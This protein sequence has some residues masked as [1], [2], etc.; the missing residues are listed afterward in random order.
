MKKASKQDTLTRVLLTLVTLTPPMLGAA[1]LYGAWA[2]GAAAALTACASN[3][4]EPEEESTSEGE[5]SGG[6]DPGPGSLSPQS[7]EAR[8]SDNIST[9]VIVSWETEE[10]STGYVEYGPT[11]ELGLSTPLSSE[12]TSHE[13]ALLGLTAETDYFYRV[14]V[15]A[16]DV[17]LDG[18]IQS[19]TTGSLP[20]G[21][22]DLEVT[23]DG[24]DQFTLVPVLGATTAITIINPEGKI[25]WYHTDDRD[26]DFY[27]ARLS[28]DGEHLIYN[29]GSVS[30]DPSDESEIVRVRLDGSGSKSVPVPLLAHDFV[31]HPDGTIGAIVVEYREVDGVTIRGDQIVELSGD[32]DIET[33]WSAWDCFD[34][35][36]D[37]SDDLEHGWT[38]ANALDYD[39]DEDA[40]YLGMR[41]FSSIAKIDRESGTCEW[42]LGFSG[43]TFDFADGSDRFLHQHQF[44]VRGD[45][46]LVLDND[47]S[48]GSES[49]V[50]EYELDF[51]NNLA[52]QVWSYVA[53]PPVYTFVLGEPTRLSDEDVFVNWSAA[54][55]LER[56]SGDETTWKLNTRAGFIFGFHTLASSLYPQ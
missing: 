30:G 56:V 6:T 40:Y 24:H 50:L 44:E 47:G 14:V 25:V 42:V 10:A 1:A 46:I 41:N 45:H 31:E 51:D 23:G 20:L 28:A 22:P 7:I 43:S 48:S 33:V 9:V 34:P 39:P 37:R 15:V 52:T 4:D 13:A 54:G 38:F 49:R 53:S 16:D 32:G 36:Q 18:K 29:A 5:L 55:Q 19:F 8:V 26:L 27:R 2:L 21:L 3:D 35:E 17:S 11:E 12:S